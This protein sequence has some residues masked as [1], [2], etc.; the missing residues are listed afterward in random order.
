MALLHSHFLCL[1]VAQLLTCT[2]FALKVAF[3][4]AVDNKRKKITI[5]LKKCDGTSVISVLPEAVVIFLIS[6]R[7]DFQLTMSGFNSCGF[8]IALLTRL[9]QNLISVK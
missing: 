3:C 7:Q 8:N 9:S 1:P 6:N 4:T 5:K 2:I